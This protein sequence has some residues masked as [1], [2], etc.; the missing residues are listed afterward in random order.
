MSQRFT[1]D[2]P[3]FEKLLAAAWVLQCVHDHLH[4]RQVEPDETISGL[5]RPRETTETRNSV[6]QLAPKPEPQVSSTAHSESEVLDCQPAGNEI[7]A[8]LVEAQQTIEN[9]TLDLDAAMQRVATLSLRSTGA[10]GSAVWLFAQRDFVYRAGA[11][12]AFD[13]ESL[14]LAVLSSLACAFPA[15]SK[16][17][18]VA[19]LGRVVKSVMVERIYHGLEVAGAV[20][21]VADPHRFSDHQR[22][23][24]R[25]MSLLLS[26]ALRKT[27]ELGLSAVE[28]NAA[29]LETVE[30]K[31]NDHLEQPTAIQA[32]SSSTAVPQKLTD[33]VPAR[34]GTSLNSRTAAS[35]VWDAFSN[36]RPTSYISLT[37][38]A[39]R[40]A[41]TATPVLL[42]AVVAALLLLE[43][44]RH[45]LHSAQA[46]SARSTE[47]RHAR[48]I[49]LLEVSHMRVTDPATFSVVQEL[50][51][52]EISGLRRQATFG[53][54]DAAFTLGMA[55][56]TGRHVTQ[57]CT[58]ATH[59]VAIAA[60]GGNAAA[61][62]NL[63]LRYRDGDGVPAD[64]AESEKWLR[65][66]SAAGNSKA[67]LALK[68]LSSG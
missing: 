68:M 31:Q 62:Y 8:E 28:P 58:Q 54:A 18:S 38:R 50:S 26:H 27:A 53:D 13:H 25:L 22:T 36:L 44:W 40:A 7:L 42:L 33:G 17:L 12:P 45:E 59:W 66:A 46:T 20:S 63:G 55:F 11:G 10:E 41:A 43:T 65:K 2:R 47:P 4:R 29:K 39:L 9:G 30:P 49:P 51:R 48:T 60:E 19:D 1:L 56:E 15:N 61:Q 16:R 14:R 21:V 64:R 34:P 57:S 3:S 6:L 32:S 35:G 23:T 67:Q 37:L 5:I 24:L 52:Y